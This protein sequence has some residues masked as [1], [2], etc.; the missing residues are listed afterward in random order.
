[1]KKIPI[2]FSFDNNYVVPAAVAFYSL[3]NK[4]AL[5][6]FY[7]M[8]VLH[9][10]ITDENQKL[11]QD[12]VQKMHNAELHFVH[13]GNFLQ[14]EWQTGNYEGH[15]FKAQFT[16]QTLL[17]CF[18]AR[19]LPHWDKVIYSDVDVVVMDDISELIDVDLSHSGGVYLAGV[20]NV[21]SLYSPSELS[22]L[23]AEHYAMLKN[24]YIAGGIWVMNLKKIRQDHL[25][26]KMLDII[27]NNNICKRWIE[28]DVM[29]IA[30]ENKTVFLPLN[31][32]AYPYLYHLLKFPEFKSL[33]SRD[34]L[35]DSI[36]SPKIIHY[37]AVKPWQTEDCDY[38]PIWWQ[39]FDY[40]KLPR[41]AIFKNH[42]LA[43]ERE[44]NFQ[45]H[46]KKQE[47]HFK[48]RKKQFLLILFL[49][50]VFIFV[51]T[52]KLFFY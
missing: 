38:A 52:F 12:I 20:K 33:Y 6:V 41:T 44:E 42:S 27:Q 2:V 17:R 16:A 43:K 14:K 11:L 18:A 15:Q 39:I 36:I 26:E 49:Q 9:N 25:E 22:H 35:Y 19:L 28:Q 30:C 37:A 47:L 10:D 3:L 29:N 46:L 7:H 5:S 13:T 45:Q 40:L 1:M 21:F 32:I 51:L 4:A 8:F 24:S 34:E 23:N 31:Y 50:S 48:K